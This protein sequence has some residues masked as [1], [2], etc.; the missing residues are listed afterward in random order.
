LIIGKY[1]GK[2]AAWRYIMKTAVA[3]VP[4]VV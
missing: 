3:A 2:A 4:A 1:L